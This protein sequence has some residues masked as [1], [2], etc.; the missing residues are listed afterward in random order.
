MTLY[1]AALT[2]L[3]VMDPFGNIPAF[4]SILNRVEPRRRRWIIAREM[5]F[6]FALLSLFLFFGTS[7]LAE[8]QISASALQISGGVIL[9]LIALR[10]IFPRG[11]SY[12]DDP[13]AAE[14]FIVPLAVPLIAGPSAMTTVTLLGTSMPGRRW[15]WFL[16]LS[17]ACAATA[18][19]LLLA[20]LIRKVLGTRLIAAIERLMGMLL[21]AIA[22]QML[23]EGLAAY[24]KTI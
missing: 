13:A 14:P 21:T 8:L 9:F 20:E 4:L 10:L 24:L 11:D 12:T 19:V 23:L 22:V 15:T 16:A 3:L 1:S 18:A 17:I 7:I 5:L 6:A 2:L